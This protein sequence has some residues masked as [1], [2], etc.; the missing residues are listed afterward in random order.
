M[1][2]NLNDTLSEMKDLKLYI[3]QN[4]SYVK[5]TWAKKIRKSCVKMSGGVISEQYRTLK[6]IP[7]GQMDG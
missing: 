4:H 2:K 3:Q 5:Y 6:I 1:Q 7:H